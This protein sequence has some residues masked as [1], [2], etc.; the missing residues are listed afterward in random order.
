MRWIFH[1]FSTVPARVSGSAKG[2]RRAEGCPKNK[3]LA[4]CL[5]FKT[6]SGFFAVQTGRDPGEWNGCAE[7]IGKMY[8]KRSK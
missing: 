1:V 3:D 5:I 7:A 8:E 2:R 4:L 6:L